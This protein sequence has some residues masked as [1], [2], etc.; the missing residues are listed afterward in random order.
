MKMDSKITCCFFMVCGLV[1]LSACAREPVTDGTVDAVSAATAA[2]FA[3]DRGAPP[4]AG[5]GYTVL[6][7]RDG[8]KA[9]AIQYDDRLIRGGEFYDDSAAKALS[10]WGV[11]T[12]V[13]ISPNDKERDFCKQHGFELVEIPFNKNDGPSEKDLRRFLDTVKN[14]R[15]RFY[16][17][18]IGGSHRGGVLGFAYRLHI[19]NWVED[20]ALV[21]FG[22]LGGDLKGDHAM[23]EAV[24]KFKP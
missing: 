9:W 1:L 8:I 7:V 14:G 6:G 13:S 19:L 4:P 18:C 12:I 23:L 22:R 16:V 2:Y 3:G 24:R 11:K 5:D 21:E 17:H 20:R 15:E 10:Q